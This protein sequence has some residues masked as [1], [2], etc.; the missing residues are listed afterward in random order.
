[1][2]HQASP[3]ECLHALPLEFPVLSR[4]RF[5]LQS[6]QVDLRDNQAHNQVDNLQINQVDS[7]Q[8][9]QQLNQVDSLQAS[10]LVSPLANP[11]VNPLVNLLDNLLVNRH[12]QLDNRRVYLL[13]Y[14]V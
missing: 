6:L 4:L 1:V 12:P 2:N 3:R 13:Q 9:S 5:P 11:L 7:L 10:L 14:L 8:A